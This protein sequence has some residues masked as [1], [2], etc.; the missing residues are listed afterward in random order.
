MDRIVKMKNYLVIHITILNEIVRVLYSLLATLIILMVLRTSEYIFFVLVVILMYVASKK[1]ISF[2]NHVSQTIK[3]FI[4][5]NVISQTIKTFITKHV[6]KNDNEIDSSS[7]SD[8]SCK[9]NSI[10]P[11]HEF[12]SDQPPIGTSEDTRQEDEVEK[13]GVEPLASYEDVWKQ[14]VF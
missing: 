10:T 2:I 9:Y 4:T 6:L 14:Q 8:E 7:E 11:L 3:N 12:P 13:I 1:I 5:K